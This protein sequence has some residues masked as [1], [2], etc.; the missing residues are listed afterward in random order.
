M[1]VLLK[2]P[3]RGRQFPVVV[4]PFHSA[5]EFVRNH[6]KVEL[7]ALPSTAQHL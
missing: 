4:H 6:G 1:P 3:P 2:R 7:S 5:H